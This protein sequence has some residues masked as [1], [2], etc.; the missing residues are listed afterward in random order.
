[1]LQNVIQPA[2][3][4]GS[5]SINRFGKR[6]ANPCYLGQRYTGHLLQSVSKML[7]VPGGWEWACRAHI[8]KGT[9]WYVKTNSL[10]VSKEPEERCSDNWCFVESWLFYDGKADIKGPDCCIT[11]SDA[12]DTKQ[13]DPNIKYGIWNDFALDYDSCDPS[14]NLDL[15]RFFVF[16]VSLSLKICFLS[17]KRFSQNKLKL[18]VKPV[19]TATQ[20][21]CEH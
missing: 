15:Y 13:T 12:L 17:I 7:C 11:Q 5:G 10:K 16:T 9:R 19:C 8:L 4:W 14:M 2:A 1:M 6:S 21:K 3:L 18:A 20:N